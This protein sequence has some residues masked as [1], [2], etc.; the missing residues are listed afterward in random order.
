MDKGIRIQVCLLVF[1]DHG[2]VIERIIMSLYIL[3][4]LF[5]CHIHMI[6]LHGHIKID[7]YIE[8]E[9]S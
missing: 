2:I 8:A 4:V 6:G 1:H 7:Y 9:N 3:L 5:Q